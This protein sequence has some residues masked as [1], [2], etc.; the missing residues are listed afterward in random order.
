MECTGGLALS[1]SF[2]WKVT[3]SDIPNLPV[4]LRHYVRMMQVN[5]IVVVDWASTD[6]FDRLTHP[7]HYN[8]PSCKCV[9]IHMI[10]HKAGSNTAMWKFQE[11]YVQIV[12]YICKQK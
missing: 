8:H 1:P 6:H 10:Q 4:Y 3:Q 11:N 5:Q 12:F 9:L 7:S 2:I